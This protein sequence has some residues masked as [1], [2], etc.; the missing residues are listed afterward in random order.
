M[1]T[2]SSTQKSALKGNISSDVET[3]DAAAVPTHTA[4]IPMTRARVSGVASRAIRADSV[5]PVKK[6]AMS[7][8]SP[9][10]PMV[11]KVTMNWLS[12]CFCSARRA[13]IDW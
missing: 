4:P 3:S 9:G 5:T 13:S 2:P 1:R 6:S 11:T 12:G 8:T 10:T 7:A